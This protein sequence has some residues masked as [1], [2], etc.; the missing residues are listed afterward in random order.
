MTNDLKSKLSSY[1]YKGTEMDH[2]IKE[3]KKEG[4]KSKVASSV[5]WEYNP[6]DKTIHC[7][8][9]RKLIGR[10]VRAIDGET[11]VETMNAEHEKTIKEMYHADDYDDLNEQCTDF[12]NKIEELEKHIADL[13]N[14]SK[15]KTH[16]KKYSCK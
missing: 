6:T 7:C 14:K 11:I 5:P 2:I 8:Y 9:N 4:Y 15:E 10:V 3:S 12:E 1:N 16:G 13:E